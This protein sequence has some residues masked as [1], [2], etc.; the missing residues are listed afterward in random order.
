M[1]KTIV[2]VLSAL[3]VAGTGAGWAAHA[4]AAP[5][6][7]VAAGEQIGIRLPVIR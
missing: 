2:T 6:P 7:G 5:W 3:V 1:I 4:N